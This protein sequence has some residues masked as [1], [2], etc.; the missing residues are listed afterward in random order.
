VNRRIVLRVTGLFATVGVLAGCGPVTSVADP[1]AAPA[2]VTT[3]T[4]TPPAITDIPAAAF[5]Q[6]TD[7]GKGGY[8]V[9]QGITSDAISPCWGAPRPSDSMLVVRE[10]V[11][12]TYRFL[13]RYDTVN[14]QAVPDG[15]INE[16][17]TSYRAGGASAYLKEVREQIARCAT[18]VYN[19][20]FLNNEIVV[21]T[22][23]RTIVAENFAGDDSL[24]WRRK[25]SGRYS[26]RLYENN[27]MIAVIRLGEVVLVVHL[28]INPG[29]PLRA[30]IDRLA[31]AAV[32]RAKSH[33]P[34]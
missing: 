34:A 10:E 4:S 24:I 26:G 17:I 6:T 3:T 20:D 1:S 19:E 11:V 23:T 30:P 12:G 32:R 21:V 9:K 27:D 22:L 8:F 7:V 14:K 5:L 15:Y 16:V 28:G 25:R 29:T 31:A 18:E 2:T 33:L 13:A